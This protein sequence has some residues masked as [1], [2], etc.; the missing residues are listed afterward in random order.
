[1]QSSGKW[2][3]AGCIDPQLWR[4]GMEE[5][6]TYNEHSNGPTSS[7]ARHG[8]PPYQHPVTPE[9]VLPDLLLFHP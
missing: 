7:S 9:L 8:P 3:K 1:M 5:G 2:G 6:G 4:T